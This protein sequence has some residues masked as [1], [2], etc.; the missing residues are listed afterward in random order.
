MSMHSQ[1]G[2]YVGAALHGLL[3]FVGA[4]LLGFIVAPLVG[5]AAGLFS[6]DAE[7]RAFF[8]LLTLKGVPYLLGLS[9][10]SALLH[11]PL[12]TR[13]LPARVG[14][15]GVNVLAVWLVAVSIALVILE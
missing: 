10:L 9:M 11:R 12:S 7:A 4:A 13:R 8:S 2:T 3:V 1:L 14:L 5:I 15:L 6:I